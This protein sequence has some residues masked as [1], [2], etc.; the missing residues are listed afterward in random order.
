MSFKDKPLK[1]IVADKRVTIDVIH[2]DVIDNF[3][4]DKLRYE[5][6]SKRLYELKINDEKDGKI[7]DKNEI[8]ELEEKINTYN[9]EKEIEYYLDTGE[10]L[11]EYY[12]QKN[13][14]IKQEKKC[15]SV[16]DIMNKN[17]NTNNMKNNK[18]DIINDY[19]SKIDDNTIP[20]I[21]EENIDICST[22][23]SQLILRHI[24]C[25]LVCEKCGQTKE[26]IINSEKTSY[27]DPPRESSYFAY[28]R[29]NH[30]NEWLAQLQAKETIDVPQEVYD[31]ILKELKKNTFLNI[32]DVKYNHIREIL[33]KLKFN[34]Y[35]EHIPHIINILNGQ[36]APVLTKSHEE[37]L[38][39][40]FKEIQTPFMNNC[41][42]ERKNFLS[43]SYVLHKFCELIELDE[44]L[45]FFPLLKSREKLQQQDK[46]WKDICKDLKWEY[47]PSI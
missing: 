39:M 24:E 7:Y 22:C 10:I 21:Y 37:Q 15:V 38:R 34:K 11:S 8:K 3:K 36:K 1:K 19:M 29:I 47:I 16:I 25:L 14:D 43:Y 23:N 30:F 2:S 26:Y 27:K 44:L 42:K 28:K 31:G 13:G 12:S 40:M 32:N 46:I 6:N 41:P 18:K 5:E 17:K 35:Y 4:K 9:P 20:D 45:V 33:K